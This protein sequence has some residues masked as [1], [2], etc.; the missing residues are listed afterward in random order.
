MVKE[1]FMAEMMMIPLQ[2]PLQAVLF[3]FVAMSLHSKFKWNNVSHRDR[4]VHILGTHRH[5]LHI[6]FIF[7]MLQDFNRL[8]IR[9]EWVH[10]FKFPRFGP[11]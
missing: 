9:T 7:S 11:Y 3:Y 10:K 8:K 2:R 4:Y 5:K 6:K 1:D